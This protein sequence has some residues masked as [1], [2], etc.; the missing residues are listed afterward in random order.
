MVF[1]FCFDL[2]VID[3]VTRW[4]DCRTRWQTW[5]R[6]VGKVFIVTA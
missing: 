2:T 4:I 3:I 6:P 5:I 1:Q